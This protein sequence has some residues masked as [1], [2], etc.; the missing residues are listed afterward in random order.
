MPPQAPPNFN[1]NPATVM[2][3]IRAILDKTRK[4]Q[5]E[6]VSNIRPENANFNN[7][8][9]PL[10]ED[11]NYTVAL[12]KLFKFFSSTST[13]EELRNA[14]N[15]SDALVSEF[16]SQTLMREDL[17][18]LID[19]VFRKEENLDAES[20]YYLNQMH[21]AFLRN[22]LGITDGPNRRRFAVIQ[23][24]LQ[25]LRVAY[26]KSLNTTT[27]IWLTNQE[28]DGFPME[29][30]SSLKTGDGENAGKVFLP[31]KKPHFEHAL[32][33]VRCQATRQKIYIGH[34][35][36][37][38]DNVPR[39]K[40][41]IL[42]RDEAARLRGYPSHAEF[43][44]VTKMA[45]STGFVND[46]LNDLKERLTP[47]AK[48]ELSALVELKRADVESAKAGGGTGRELDE[49]T[50]F[51]HWDFGFYSNLTKVQAYSFEEKDFSEYF[52]LERS[53]AGMMSTFS[54]LFGLQ[55]CRVLSD[56]FNEFGPDHVMTWHPDVTV[57]TVWEDTTNGGE[58]LG[59]LYLDLFPRENKYNHAGHYNLRPVSVS[60]ACVKKHL[61]S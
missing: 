42:L 32:R 45:E 41:A 25:E 27:G 14:S 55:F 23:K 38:L 34:D 40:A 3:G 29:S 17:F 39:L 28:L 48:M 26:L 21:Q 35:N 61:T 11:E 37:C 7:V 18:R 16:N 31:L 51:H 15:E 20:Q 9:L 19:A 8:L 59:Y 50:R 46:F 12:K 44:L 36:R 54:R 60:P 56:D 43:Q 5:D 58:F 57:F 30:L 53:L 33:F 2:A 1:H 49:N 10:A 22:G 13:S 24:E 47:I 6:I 4:I 52:S